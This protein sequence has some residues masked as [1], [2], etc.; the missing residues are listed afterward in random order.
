MKDHVMRLVV[1]SVLGVV[2]FGLNQLTITQA[3]QPVM[4]LAVNETIPPGGR[5]KEGSLNV[6]AL[7]G[8]VPAMRRNLVLA[9]ARGTV[10]ERKAVRKL[11]PGE[12][13]LYSDLDSR[14]EM[15]AFPGH[16]QLVY[17]PI[18]QL[19][20]RRDLIR[21][22]GRVFFLVK[23][24]ENQPPQRIGPYEVFE[25]PASPDEAPHGQR[26]GVENAVGVLLRQAETE[27]AD[28]LRAAIEHDAIRAI[29]VEPR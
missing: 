19:P 27:R 8:Q 9:T 22:G 26:E 29:E 4:V 10:L 25:G 15:P 14:S 24:R 11:E 23:A 20:C 3:I 1:P 7:P 18:G 16:C 2:G 13:L 17:I 5:V 21:P 12:L 28:V 6:V